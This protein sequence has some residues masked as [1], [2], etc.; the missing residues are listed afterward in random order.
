MNAPCVPS[1]RLLNSG[2]PQ[3]SRLTAFDTIIV[4]LQPPIAHAV[5]HG[6]TSCS[7]A[8]SMLLNCQLAFHATH[9]IVQAAGAQWRQW[10]TRSSC[11]VRAS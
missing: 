11:A 1:A 3:A 4:Q 8:A 5:Q 6:L 9:C 2:T 7:L 10:C